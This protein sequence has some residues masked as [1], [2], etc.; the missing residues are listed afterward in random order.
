MTSKQKTSELCCLM[1]AR[2]EFSSYPARPSVHLLSQLIS[3]WRLWD[4]S[5]VLKE[6]CAPTRR[7]RQLQYAFKQLLRPF[8]Y[9]FT[10]APSNNEYLFCWS[11]QFRP[12]D[13]MAMGKPGERITGDGSE[14]NGDE[15]AQVKMANFLVCLTLLIHVFM[16][17]QTILTAYPQF[18]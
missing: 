17:N 10:A 18:R 11:L 8:C 12:Q 16:A 1:R 6:A 2:D 3:F 15:K 9:F 13:T 7:S 5:R 14:S 4:S